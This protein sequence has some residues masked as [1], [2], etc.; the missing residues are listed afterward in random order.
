[1]QES[2]ERIEYTN[3]CDYSTPAIIISLISSMI[4][5]AMLFAIVSLV[6]SE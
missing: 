2:E 4:R 6:L 5:L 1:M 3:Y